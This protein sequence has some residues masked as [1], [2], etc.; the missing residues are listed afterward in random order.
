MPWYKRLRW[1]LT[2]IPLT[3]VVV[4]V[5]WMIVLVQWMTT[6]QLPQLFATLLPETLSDSPHLIATLSQTVRNMVLTI[7]AMVASGAIILG[8][9]ASYWLWRT[10]VTPLHKIAHNSQRITDGHYSERVPVPDN[11]GEAMAQVVTNFNQMAATLEQIEAQR[12]A[13]ISNVTHELRTPLAG[14]KGYVEGLEDGVFTADATTLQVMG[15][16][17]GRLTHLIDDIQTL[18]RVEA[19]TLPIEK[20]CLD[21]DEIIAQVM[22]RLQ[23]TFYYKQQKVVHTRSQEAALIAADAERTAQIITN[24]LGN[25]TQYTPQNGTITLTTTIGEKMVTLSVCD[26]GI[27]ISAET[28]PYIFERFYRVDHSRSRQSGGS[29]IGLTIARHL[30][31]QMNGDL[32]VTSDGV[33]HGSCF[34]LSLPKAAPLQRRPDGF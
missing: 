9:L 15:K 33:G 32:T 2:A 5:L 3:V 34:T 27:G 19:N 10:V 7:V 6:M 20:Q 25:A 16:E 30:A 13:M 23:A 21:L 29:G 18:S 22:T 17:I 4:S 12:I 28:L 1:R 14:L 24:L 8:C 26:T 31:W 11:V